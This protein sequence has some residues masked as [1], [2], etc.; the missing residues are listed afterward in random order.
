[1][2]FG[3]WKNRR[4]MNSSEYGKVVMKKVTECDVLF[5]VHVLEKRYVVEASEIAK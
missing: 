1:M 5:K 3:H 4:V 2:A